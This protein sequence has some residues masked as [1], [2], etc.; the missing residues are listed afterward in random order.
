MR[1]A[2]KKLTGYFDQKILDFDLNK[3]DLNANGIFGGRLGLIYYFF[4]RYKV[5]PKE[6]Y[7]EKI[8]VLL[9]SSFENC[10]NE[11]ATIS[12]ELNLS[13][14]LCGLGFILNEL[15]HARVIDE[16]Y[17]EQLI[18]INDLALEYTR[19][20]IQERNFDFFYGATGG[21]FY[22][23]EVNELDHCRIIIYELAK[24]APEYDFLYH[25]N[26]EDEFN[27]GINFGL[28]HGNTAL[29]TV[30]MRLQKKGVKSEALKKLVKK[31]VKKLLTYEQIAFIEG[32][33]IKVYFPHNIILENKKK[34][35]NHSAILGWCNSELDMA[36]LMHLYNETNNTSQLAETAEKIST[37]T[38]KRKT[39]NATG[40]YDH[41]FC[42]GSSGV[43]QLYKKLFNYTQREQ[44][45][46]AYIY[47]CRETM[48]YLEKEK[49]AEVTA[50]KLN[51]LY[52]WPAALLT[53]NEY[54]NKAINGW[55]KLF[56]I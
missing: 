35:I 43:A 11:A 1:T 41:H 38:L 3:L 22:L 39:E 4:Y 7:L 54:E 2:A 16:S 15:M 23:S 17:V 18:T 28:A 33:H 44:Y 55:D 10:N 8:G 53:L 30:L 37:E 13:D 47:W 27:K 51:F 48:N 29:F 50:D 49:E 31:G 42:H 19:R 24:V 32:E 20:A 14:G 5:D 52:G 9:E 34:K 6:I 56:L 25:C 40:V 12:S 46:E 36:L 45:K 26:H 21:L